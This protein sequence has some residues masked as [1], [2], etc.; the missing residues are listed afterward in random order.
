MALALPGNAMAQGASSKVQIGD[1]RFELRLE[2]AYD[3]RAFDPV[4]HED[5]DAWRLRRGGINGEIGNHLEF[6]IE[7]D[8]DDTGRWRD[9]YVSWRT[10]RQSSVSAGR[11]KA[12]FG[13][14][15]TYEFG[16]F[17][18]DGDKARSRKKTSSR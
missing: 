15:L 13:R 5:R 14:G 2:L 12:P 9:V 8:L 7:R 3:L 17:D 6:Q 11:Y 1:I 18:D 10:F 16:V 4:I